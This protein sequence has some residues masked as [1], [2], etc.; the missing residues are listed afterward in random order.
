MLEK[1]RKRKRW[2]KDETK[3]ESFLIAKKSVERTAE[4]NASIEDHIREFIYMNL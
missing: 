2:R 4:A 3:K 1:M